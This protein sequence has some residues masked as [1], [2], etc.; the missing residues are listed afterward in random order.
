MLRIHYRTLVTALA[1]V[2]VLGAAA[3]ASAQKAKRSSTKA[4]SSVVRSSSRARASTPRVR[5][6][7]TRSTSRAV[8]ARTPSRV[9]TRSAVRVNRAPQSRVS[10][11]KVRTQSRS[12][13]SRSKV[14]VNRAPQEK[15]RSTKVRTQ[16]RNA[17]NRSTVR[18]NKAT[19]DRTGRVK[20]RG[21]D[22]SG[23]VRNT[24]RVNK[25]KTDRSS[26]GRSTVKPTVKA[27]SAN[28]DPIVIA[29]E[30]I[31]NTV[32]GRAAA[33]DRRLD[34]ARR[35][36]RD[37]GRR[38]YRDGYRYGYD[39]GYY[40]GYRRGYRDAYYYGFCYGFCYP[41]YRYYGPH[42]VFG[43]HYGGFGFYHGRWHF[44]LVLGSPY[45]HHYYYPYRYSWWDGYYSSLVTWDR[46]VDVRQ[47]DYA[48]DFTGRTCVELWIRTTDGTV[49]EIKT[50]PRFWDARDPGDLYAALWSELEREGQLQIEDVNGAVHVFP[51]GM[52]QQIEARECN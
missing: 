36:R 19:Q 10:P 38:G 25:A 42:H 6:Q 33:E 20:I 9:N 8:Q 11:A 22:R 3:P 24:V 23:E 21:Q 34:R 28:R 51:A 39:G 30:K 47:T 1:A 44:V 40:R 31:A 29:K 35:D 32:R 12:A 48:F 4:R 17:V 18:V 43:Y 2:V 45:V 46:A 16:S 15:V 13:V 49:Y 50:D 14:R 37:F 5:S 52:I 27:R 41:Y 7:P 26:V